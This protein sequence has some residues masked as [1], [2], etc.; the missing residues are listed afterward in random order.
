MKNKEIP[1]RVWINHYSKLI[2]QW[3]E[4]LNKP[5]SN[6]ERATINR[7]INQT[8]KMIYERKILFQEDTGL[9]FN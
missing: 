5:L 6:I 7:K 1:H 8:T 2:D 3:K 4:E 9:K